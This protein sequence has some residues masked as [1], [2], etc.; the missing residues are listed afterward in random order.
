MSQTHPVTIKRIDTTLPLP[1]Y[2]TAG[3]CGFDLYSRIEKIIQPREITLLPTNLIIAV[4]ADYVLVIAPRSS[5]AMKKGLI[6]P[7]SMGIIDQDFCGEADEIMMQ[8]QNITDQPVRVERGERLGQ[9]IFLRYAV[10]AWQETEIMAQ[11]S[12]GGFGTTGQLEESN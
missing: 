2:K 7:H 3:A 8:V 4:P 5:L 11:P 10:A 6:M 1:S 9:G 12:R